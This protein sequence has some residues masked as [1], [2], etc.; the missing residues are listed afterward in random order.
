MGLVSTVI[1]AFGVILFGI[2]TEVFRCKS[3]PNIKRAPAT[4]PS[5]WL[6]ETEFTGYHRFA[7]TTR[8][9]T[10]DQVPQ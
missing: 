5:E 1:I 8:I 6:N 9:L 7:S 4:A 2:K 10:C 3:G